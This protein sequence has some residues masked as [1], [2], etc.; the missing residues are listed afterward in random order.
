MKFLKYLIERMDDQVLRN[1]WNDKYHLDWSLWN[2]IWSILKRYQRE[3]LRSLARFHKYAGYR[4]LFIK[5]VDSYTVYRGLNLANNDTQINSYSLDKLKKNGYMPDNGK[6]YSWTSDLNQ[7]IRFAY[8]NRT[9]MGDKKSWSNIDKMF[10]YYGVVL[11]HAFPSKEVLFDLDYIEEN[12][13]NLD[14][15]E[16][17]V[18]VVP[19]KGRQYQVFKYILE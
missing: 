12:L 15:A 1:L 6:M 17:E 9:W 14:F 3:D 4:G 8:G 2:E 18:V 16:S 11:K 5:D 10:N 13:F 7:A 19:K